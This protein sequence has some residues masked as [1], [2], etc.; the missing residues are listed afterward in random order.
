[1][2]ELSE[3]ERARVARVQEELEEGLANLSDIGPAISGN[4]RIGSRY[5]TRYCRAIA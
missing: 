5:G 4:Q 3:Q 1:M 2:I